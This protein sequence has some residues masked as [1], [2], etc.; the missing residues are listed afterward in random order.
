MIKNTL[1]SNQIPRSGIGTLNEKNL[2]AALVQ[3]FSRPGDE[4]ESKVDEYIVDIKRKNLLIEVQIKNFSAIK[5]K[6]RN[7]C[8]KH[9]IK[10]IHPIAQQK[11]II[12]E[13][14]DGERVSKRKSP[15]RGR[16]EDIFTEL[17]RIP[18]ILSESNFSLCVVL[19]NLNEIWKNDGQGSWRRS[20]WSIADRYLIEVNE[21]HEFH[22]P[23]DLR[24]L[25][26]PSIPGT[27]TNHDVAAHLGIS[28]S[29]AGKMTYC[30]RKLK[31]L[32]VVGKKGRA[33]LMSYNNKSLR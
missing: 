24:N 10:L 28:N 9:K 31:E 19:V 7:L 32:K 11:W 20:N 4:F 18:T 23:K 25:L 30:L 26:P 21:I 14:A 15:K 8:V 6:L 1:E 22:H 27:F 29:L 17:I 3:W 33:N 16:V 5:E 13:E 2:H 12:K